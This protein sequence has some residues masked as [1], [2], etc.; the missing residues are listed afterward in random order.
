MDEEHVP[1]ASR[2]QVRKELLALLDSQDWDSVLQDL[3]AFTYSALRNRI[4]LGVWGGLVPGARDAHDIVMASVTDIIDGIRSADDRVPLIAVLKSVIR[5]KISGLAKSLESLKTSR[6]DPCPDEGEVDQQIAPHRPLEH[7]REQDDVV[8][9]ETEE[10]N[11]QLLD[12]L[13][14][15]L[16]DEPDLQK[17]IECNIDGVF[18]REEIATRLGK[19]VS[20]ITN[21]GKRLKR[22]LMAFS[23][24]FADKNPFTE[25]NK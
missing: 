1:Q 24:K 3:L 10:I 14:G 2:T 22:R 11:S 7:G 13:I 8:S 25:P 20:E 18:K 21:I 5:S 9:K 16:S 23:V 4:W 12:L 15:E 19:T 6:F 17:I